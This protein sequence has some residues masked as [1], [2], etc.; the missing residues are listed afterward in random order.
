M[1][2]SGVPAILAEASG[3]AL[4]TGAHAIQ[5]TVSGDSGNVIEATMLNGNNPDP[6]VHLVSRQYPAMFAEITETPSTSP[7]I[8]V[9]TVGAGAGLR[10][11]SAHGRGAELSTGG[12]AQVRLVPAADDSHPTT[13]KRGDLFVDRH[14]RLWFCRG[15]S[16]WKQLA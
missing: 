1:I 10:A 16:N 14:G 2:A 12:P 13:G 8:A 3:G 11:A 4:G 7:V 9:D 5:A 15:T 6:V